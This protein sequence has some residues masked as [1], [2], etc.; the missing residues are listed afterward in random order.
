MSLSD[1]VRA[2]L[3]AIAPARE[4]DRLAELCALCHAAG[5]LHLHGQGSVSLHLDLSD[6]PAARRAFSLLRSFDVDAE[7]RTYRRRS[8]DRGTRYQLHVP[9]EPRAL[10]VLNEAGVLSASLGPRDRPPRRV[11][12]RTCCRA[13]YIRG[14]LLGAGSVTGPRAPHL[15]LRTTNAGG[16]LFL[17]EVAAAAGVPL[18]VQE[19]PRHAA[20]Y[21]KGAETVADMLALAGASE[22]AL[23]LDEAAVVAEARARANRLANA[24]HANLVRGGR[25]AHR[26][27]QA[28]RR[29][30]RSGQLVRV[31]VR[32][33]EI[34]ELR[35]RYPSASLAELATKARPAITKASAH[36]RLA[37]L[38]RLADE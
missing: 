38:V 35:Q 11:A 1:E 3:A 32:L 14:A 28:I 29:L 20:A 27:L 26:Q 16:A 9:G 25:A 36:R 10:Q 13:A 6:G 24:D 8:F 30:E 23:L 34:A 21:A 37:K 18:K 4:C 31:P 5:R 12:A 2:E 33:R 22:A 15:E 17:A 19:R 7:I